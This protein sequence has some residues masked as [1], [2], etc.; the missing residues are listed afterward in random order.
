MQS[1]LSTHGHHS[2]G[3]YKS[4][5]TKTR[6]TAKR[7][8]LGSLSRRRGKLGDRVAGTLVNKDSSSAASSFAA[9]YDGDFST[10]ANFMASPD[11]QDVCKYIRRLKLLG[12]GPFRLR[13]EGRHRVDTHEELSVIPLGKCINLRSIILVI[14]DH[15]ESADVED[16]MR[17]LFHG[18]THL[19]ILCQIIGISTGAYHL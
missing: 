9:R 10:L 5:Y 17:V 12:R 13:A 15:N 4:A 2:G 1:A 14:D 7:T 11:G 3:H 6:Y 18:H 8:R 19:L 16:M